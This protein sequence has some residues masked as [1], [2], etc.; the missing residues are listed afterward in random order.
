MKSSKKLGWKN[1]NEWRKKKKHQL[2]K[3]K[4]C[5]H[6]QHSLNNHYDFFIKVPPNQNTRVLMFTSND[7]LLVVVIVELMF[8]KLY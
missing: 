1:A 8:E 6:I 4:I 3:L 7:I 5:L 2:V